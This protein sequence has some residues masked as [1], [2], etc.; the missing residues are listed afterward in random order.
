MRQI[1]RT[2]YRQSH[3]PERAPL[4][5]NEGLILVLACDWGLD[6]L[7]R[8]RVVAGDGT[9]ATVPSMFTQAFILATDRHDVLWPCMICLMPARSKNAYIT[10]L[11]WCRDNGIAI[12]SRLGDFERASI[13]VECAR[14]IIPKT[15]Q[16]QAVKAVFPACGVRL[17]YFRL[18]QSVVRHINQS[19]LKEL[20]ERDTMF[21]LS[22]RPIYCHIYLLSCILQVKMVVATC[23]ARPNDVPISTPWR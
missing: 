2:N 3:G 20:H 14:N 13:E 15:K 10:I 18:T 5:I 8:N 19:G 4:Q 12:E 23:F 21:A 9:F 16:L 6:L 22:A 1:F 7:R 11:T 17:C